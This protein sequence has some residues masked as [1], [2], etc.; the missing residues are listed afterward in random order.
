[1]E[2]RKEERMDGWM[3]GSYMQHGAPEA[4]VSDS[5][6]VVNCKDR[7][8]FFMISNTVDTNLS[9]IYHTANWSTVS[10]RNQI[11]SPRADSLYL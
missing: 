8:V 9:S 10:S 5:C 3:N 6:E 2:G 4:R 1:M 11:L 7:I